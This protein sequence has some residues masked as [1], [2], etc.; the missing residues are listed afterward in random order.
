MKPHSSNLP[1][2]RVI[3]VT[4]VPEEKKYNQGTEISPALDPARSPLALERIQVLDSL[5]KA[6][7]NKL[8]KLA[9]AEQAIV[10]LLE[11][12]RTYDAFI[13]ERALEL[14]TPPVEVA[15]MLPS[16]EIKK[17]YLTE[18]LLVLAKI[19][20]G[21]GSLAELCKSDPRA[22]SS[23]AEMTNT[24]PGAPEFAPLE[25]LFKEVVA[26]Q[27]K[28][29]ELVREISHKARLAQNKLSM[30]VNPLGD[31]AISSRLE[32][33]STTLAEVTKQV[34]EKKPL[35]IALRGGATSIFWSEGVLS[36]QRVITLVSQ[37]YALAEMVRTEVLETLP[38]VRESRERIGRAVV[39]N[40]PREPL[41]QSAGLAPGDV[42]ILR[43]A[44]SHF[45]SERDT[46]AGD[47]PQGFALKADQHFRDLESTIGL[48]Q[49]RSMVDALEVERD[50]R[51]AWL[52]RKQANSLRGVLDRIQEERAS[53]ERAR[54]LEDAFQEESCAEVA[55][56]QEP[57][58]GEVSSAPSTEEYLREIFGLQV[59]QNVQDKLAELP[60]IEQVEAR[61]VMLEDVAAFAFG[62]QSAD[63]S[64]ALVSKMLASNPHLLTMPNFDEYCAGLKRAL[65]RIEK[66]GLTK[67]IYDI[68]K[69]THR[70]SGPSALA[71]TV[72]C[73]E[74]ASS[75]KGA[76]SGLNDAGLKGEAIMA[77]LRYGF[78]FNG[79]LHIGPQIG[80]DRKIYDNANNKSEKKIPL[81]ELEE[82]LKTL[83]QAGI[84]TPQ[85]RAKASS[86]S[87]KGI[88]AILKRVDID[89]KP[90]PKESPV[91]RRPESDAERREKARTV[92]LAKALKWVLANSDSR[93]EF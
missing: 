62:T 60:S 17:R 43:Y 69:S 9:G 22:Q 37:A 92:A 19:K 31:P 16:E 61:T 7:R 28:K 10:E 53:Q 71:E 91:A 11:A 32:S 76:V 26:A 8:G 82:E 87:R 80:E 38:Q 48:E 57:L 63:S 14:F 24:T 64:F 36:A 89:E 29:E 83:R 49:V 21:V 1:F 42:A 33:F 79:Q 41:Q 30:L 58:V 13:S 74:R 27:T 4:K 47:M 72:A 51:I 46:P 84:I 68:M 78:F 77:L 88:D 34:S 86:L 70:F 18:G 20:R 93:V 54:A 2:S 75:Y 15:M 23:V 50:G 59:L 45:P 44:W 73:I 35:K 81:E 56:H 65:T 25:R 12:T 85:A 40:L 55:S 52:T 66:L 3:A 90:K 5:Q 39:K 67:P 6:S